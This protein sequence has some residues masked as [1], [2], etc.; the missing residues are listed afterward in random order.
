MKRPTS[1]FVPPNSF[2][3]HAHLYRSV[4]ATSAWPEGLEDEHG[5]VGWQAWQN[6]LKQWM[7][8][9]TPT[10][11]LFFT[12][13]KPALQRTEANHFVADEVASHPESRTL[14][15]IHP[16]DD[17]SS[18]EAEVEARRFVGF[19]VY[20]VYADRQDTFNAECHEFLP[21]WAWEMA[22][23]QGLAIMLH[24]VRNRALCSWAKSLPQR[25]V[26]NNARSFIEFALHAGGGASRPTAGR[27]IA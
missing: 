18:V 5:Q 26:P 19:K 24:M 15:L 16:Q 3:A 21:D 10:A 7:G 17:P 22:D 8:N 27:E 11:G 14:M 9:A 13:P 25:Q 20:H 4:D 1:G 23:R 12:V 2:D 6:A